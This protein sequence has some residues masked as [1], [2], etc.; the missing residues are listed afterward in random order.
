MAEIEFETVRFFDLTNTNTNSGNTY[1]VLIYPIVHLTYVILK[2]SKL[3]YC[4][5]DMDKT[6]NNSDRLNEF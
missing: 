2:T 4:S 3:S 5:Y 1:W 6:E